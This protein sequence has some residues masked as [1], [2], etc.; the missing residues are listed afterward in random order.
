MNRAVFL[1]NEEEAKTVEK[2]VVKTQKGNKASVSFDALSW[3]QLP[4]LHHIVDRLAEIP[5]YEVVEAKLVE[6]TGVSDVSAARAWI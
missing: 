4:T 1:P 2:K 3:K 6:G 5:V